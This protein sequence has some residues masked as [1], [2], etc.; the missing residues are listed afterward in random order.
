MIK[1]FLVTY[2]VESGIVGDT[3]DYKVV[4][5]QNTD[6]VV[7]MVVG[8]SGDR[9]DE[10]AS[11]TNKKGKLNLNKVVFIVTDLEKKSTEYLILEFRSGSS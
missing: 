5:E 3:A 2:D 6:H 7:N 8:I 4:V 11:E 10:E 9:A 1:C